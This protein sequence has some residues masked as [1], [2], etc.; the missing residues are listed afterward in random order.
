MFR[1]EAQEGCRLIRS[2]WFLGICSRLRDAPTPSPTIRYSRK[3]PEEDTREGPVSDAAAGGDYLLAVRLM[4]PSALVTATR[5]RRRC[6]RR[7]RRRRWRC[8]R[9][10][11]LLRCGV[12]DITWRPQAL[13][14]LQQLTHEVQVRADDRTRVLHQFVRLHHRQAFVP[15]YIS[16][17]DCCAARY[18]SLTVHQHAA[19]SLPRFLWNK[20]KTNCEINTC[21]VSSL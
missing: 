8:R 10:R 16:D 18:T 3:R 6:R 21:F 2:R 5:R 19:S 7:R 12:G 11:G 13:L 15:H 17:R 4:T 1:V 20:K 9:R 14:E